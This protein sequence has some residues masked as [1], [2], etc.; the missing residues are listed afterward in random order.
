MRPFGKPILWARLPFTLVDFW[1]VGIDS[2]YSVK[3]VH[4]GL[5]KTDYPSKF[6]PFE[7]FNPCELNNPRIS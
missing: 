6:Y 3:V 4:L 7:M 5:Q 2:F 1:F